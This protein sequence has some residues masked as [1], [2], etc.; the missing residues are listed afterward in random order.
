M[1]PMSFTALASVYEKTFCYKWDEE[2]VATPKQLEEGWFQF[3]DRHGAEVTVEDR[4]RSQETGEQ[5]D[6]KEEVDDRIMEEEK[7]VESSEESK[8]SEERK[9]ER[10]EDRV[11]SRRRVTDKWKQSGCQ[12]HMKFIGERRVVGEAYEMLLLCQKIGCGR[13]IRIS[14]YCTKRLNLRGKVSSTLR[15][16]GAIQ[17]IKTAYVY[18]LVH[19]LFFLLSGARESPLRRYE[20]LMGRNMPSKTTLFKYCHLWEQPIQDEFNAEMEFQK[21]RQ[22]LI[23]DSMKKEECSQRCLVVSADGAWSHRGFS[24]PQFTYIVLDVS[25]DWL[26]IAE[27]KRKGLTALSAGPRPHPPIMF[28][29]I[30]EKERVVDTYQ[31]RRRSTRRKNWRLPHRDVTGESPEN[32]SAELT[33]SVRG[34]TVVGNFHRCGG[35]AGMEGIG[36]NEFIDVID[37][38]G[39]KQALKMFV[40]DR[41]LKVGAGMKRRCPD[42]EKG[43]DPGHVKKQMQAMLKLLFTKQIPFLY[44]EFRISAFIIR[45][46]KMAELD[47]EL[48]MDE[49]ARLTFICRRM[50]QRME[51]A[52]YHYFN[53]C[54]E[55]CPHRRSEEYQDSPQDIAEFKQEEENNEFTEESHTDTQTD[56]NPEFTEE[57]LTDNQSEVENNPEFTEESHG[58]SQSEVGEGIDRLSQTTQFCPSQRTSQ[59]SVSHLEAE[60]DNGGQSRLPRVQPSVDCSDRGNAVISQFNPGD[61]APDCE[62][63][64]NSTQLSQASTQSPSTESGQVADQDDG[65]PSQSS[66]KSNDSG[67][68]KKKKTKMRK[69]KKKEEEKTEGKSLAGDISVIA[70]AARLALHADQVKKWTEEIQRREASQSQEFIT[71]LANAEEKAKEEFTGFR[72]AVGKAKVL[73]EKRS[74]KLTDRINKGQCRE[75]EAESERKAIES[76]RQRIECKRKELSGP[77]RKLY[78]RTAMNAA[79]AEAAT[80]W[81]R[82]YGTTYSDEAAMTQVLRV[83]SVHPFFKWKAFLTT[84]GKKAVWRNFLALMADWS[85]EKFLTTI[86][87]GYHTCH[88]ECINSSRA[89]WGTSKEAVMWFTFP[90]RC[91]VTCLRWNKGFAFV[92]SLCRRLGVS[93]TAEHMAVVREMDEDLLARAASTQSREGR[94]KMANLK[95]RRAMR[96]GIAHEKGQEAKSWKAAQKRRDLKALTDEEK[97]KLQDGSAVD[98]EDT[99]D[100]REEDSDSSECDEGLSE[101]EKSSKGGLSSANAA[102]EEETPS[103]RSSNSNT[104]RKKR[105]T[106]SYRTPAEKA[107]PMLDSLHMDTEDPQDSEPPPRPTSRGKRRKPSE[108]PTKAS[109]GKRRQPSTSG[110]DQEN[111]GKA[112]GKVVRRDQPSKRQALRDID[113][114]LNGVVAV[115]Q[116]ARS[117][118]S[119]QLPAS[120]P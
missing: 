65:S 89:R 56:D 109:R 52:V 29:H 93:L 87:H 78:V 51:Q 115:S 88:L 90:M 82:P 102:S 30:I 100:E 54:D 53:V 21:K 116:K 69:K 75:A 101:N 74:A 31:R 60:G 28:M 42:V 106:P 58:E 73:L 10:K 20:N 55:H 57:S 99:D 43:W 39:R 80:R 94:K 8:D 7:K 67:K 48:E 104:K 70:N 17:H 9:E 113:N 36:W 84:A 103:N 4:D 66:A 108:P 95:R 86:C 112:A 14:N 41:D 16:T 12:G 62:T 38:D 26:A 18:E 72:A 97:S 92:P 37:K 110:D 76:E 23:I 40:S 49:Q 27:A 1:I 63:G 19:S 81:P 25:R 71:F 96:Q 24:A 61:S 118:V 120:Q 50:Q 107:A 47:S 2:S 77:A 45:S 68:R 5:T 98:S 34:Y 83:G 35:S 91:N 33:K 59:V 15:Q 22:Q 6:A 117:K 105:S 32:N 111:T 64:N 13:F 11:P 114:I 85:T 44:L 119:W 3:Y 46:L 79:N